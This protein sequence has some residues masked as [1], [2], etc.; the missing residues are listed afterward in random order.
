MNIHHLFVEA[1]AEADRLAHGVA[2]ERIAGPTPCPEFDTRALLNH[3]IVYTSHGMEHRALRTTLPEETTARDFVAEPDWADAYGAQLRRAVAAWA[4]PAVWEGE[5]DFG[6]GQTMPATEIAAMLL[7]ELVLHGWDVARAT[8]QDYRASAE[9]GEA[10]EG[11]VARYAEMYREYA[12]FAVPVA[13]PE[14]ASAFERAL[15]AS[16]RDAL[17]KP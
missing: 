7:L 10:V 5:I 2:P 12:G 11:I 15:G 1:S 17:W 6:G 4:E 13:V 16:G 9:L 8:G 3:W 14:D